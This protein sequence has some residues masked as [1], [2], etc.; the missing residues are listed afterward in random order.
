MD[1]KTAVERFLDE[2]GGLRAHTTQLAYGNGTSALLFHLENKGL[3]ATS[4]LNCLT[5]DHLISFPAYLGK[6]GYA[7]KTISL[8]TSS[9]RSFARWMIIGGYLDISPRDALRFEMAFKDANQRRETRLPRWP[10]RDDVDKLLAAVRDMKEDSPRYERNIALLEF[11]ASTGCRNNEVCG[12]KVGSIN[13]E[14]RSAVVVG[15]GSK[16]RVV[17]FSG[18]ALQEMRRYWSVR[19]DAALGSPVFASHDK[20]SQGRETR[21]VT[22]TT[23]RNIVKDVMNVAGIQKFS[24]HYFRHAFAIKML[25]E[26]DNLALV[27]DLLG[28]SD[29]AAT[30]VYAK[31][32]PDDLRDLHHRVFK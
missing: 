6:M 5:I 16:E 21:H 22:T 10:Q 32:Y 27:Q 25:K 26:T 18:A 24:P 7:K 31:I 1:I 23:V 11:L 14:D 4:P 30:R 17:F 9:V 29:P 28:H 20:G 13:V 15:K 2:L 3:P 8:Y 19:N 12:L